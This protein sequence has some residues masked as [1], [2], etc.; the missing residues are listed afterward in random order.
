MLS[1]V[2]IERRCQVSRVDRISP[3]SFLLVILLEAECLSVSAAVPTT[4]WRM[5]GS[6]DSRSASFSMRSGRLSAG[7]T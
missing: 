3:I 4:T 1:D 7:G 6:T 2:D 5:A